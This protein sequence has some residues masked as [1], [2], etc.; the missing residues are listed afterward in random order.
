MAQDAKRRVPRSYALS[1]SGSSKVG[2]RVENP[3]VPQAS[4]VTLLPECDRMRAVCREGGRLRQVSLV[5]RLDRARR[6]A[7]KQ[8]YFPCETYVDH[9]AAH[10]RKLTSGWA[11]FLPLQPAPGSRWRFSAWPS[12]LVT[13]LDPGAALARLL[14]GRPLGRSENPNVQR[15]SGRLLAVSLADPSLPG[16]ITTIRSR[17][18]V[19][20]PIRYCV[21][22]CR[23]ST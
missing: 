20:V 10:F 7:S 1:R 2:T 5:R 19:W 9:P 15:Q 23:D 14:T 18:Q 21:K 6:Q 13:L 3:K 4:H 8:G 12:A 17:P 22:A 11:R 16:F